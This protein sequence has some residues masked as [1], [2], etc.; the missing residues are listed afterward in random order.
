MNRHWEDVEI[1]AEQ[2]DGAEKMIGGYGLCGK[3]RRHLIAAGRDCRQQGATAGSDQPGLIGRAAE[4]RA[5]AA[6]EGAGVLGRRRRLRA[7]AES[8]ATQSDDGQA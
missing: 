8:R 3:Q 2:G 7:A 4:S 1:G 5:T 6:L